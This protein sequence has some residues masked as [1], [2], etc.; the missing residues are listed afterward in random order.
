MRD[1]NKSRREGRSENKVKAISPRRSGCPVQREKPRSKLAK[2]KVSRRGILAKM[3]YWPAI[4]TKRK[5][6]Q[7]TQVKRSKMT[8]KSTLRLT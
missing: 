2:S 1:R 3:N 6:G 7:E 5:K 4:Q 8:K